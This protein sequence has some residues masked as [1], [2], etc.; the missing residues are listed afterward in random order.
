MSSHL[1]AR[2]TKVPFGSRI[3]RTGW[4][5]PY[6]GVDC[7]EIG[8]D[9]IILERVFSSD[10]G[11]LCQKK[12]CGR[13]RT[14]FTCHTLHVPSCG[15]YRCEQAHSKQLNRPSTRA[16]SGVAKS[17]RAAVVGVVTSTLMICRGGWEASTEVDSLAAY[18]FPFLQI[19]FLGAVGTGAAFRNR[20]C[21]SVSWRP[22]TDPHGA[23]W[24]TLL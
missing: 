10:T 24:G 6:H 13:V 18:T 9:E 5:S 1:P 20:V 19:G 16:S 22:Q 7:L 4:D 2:E 11:Q 12:T 8:S 3:V 14:S 15:W 17:I 23:T 21:R